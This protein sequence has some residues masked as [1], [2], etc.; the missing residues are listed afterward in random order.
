MDPYQVL[1][2]SIDASEEDIKAAYK[3]M[4]GA[5]TIDFLE[6]HSHLRYFRPS[7]GIP[8]AMLQERK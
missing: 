3:R 1:D 7:A 6:T 2:I 5:C 8:I 4:V